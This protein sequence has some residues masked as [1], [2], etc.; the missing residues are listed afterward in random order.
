MAQA[1][2]S[3]VMTSDHRYFHR[4]VSTDDRGVDEID[5]DFDDQIVVDPHEL[6]APSRR[7]DEELGELLSLLDSLETGIDRK[8]NTR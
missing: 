5:R 2:G 4:C 7:S 3:T 6:H 1:E 8:V